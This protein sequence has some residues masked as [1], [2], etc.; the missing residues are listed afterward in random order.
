MGRNTRR[1]SHKPKRFKVAGKSQIAAS[2]R[3]APTL[4]QKP[5]TFLLN[6]PSQSMDPGMQKQVKAWLSELTVLNISMDQ[7]EL[8]VEKCA[9]PY[10]EK[11]AHPNASI[12]ILDNCGYSIFSFAEPIDSWIRALKN[13]DTL[14]KSSHRREKLLRELIHAHLEQATVPKSKAAPKQEAFKDK[15]AEIWGITDGLKTRLEETGTAT[16]S[17]NVAKQLLEQLRSKLEEI[18]NLIANDDSL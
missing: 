7:L 17:Q 6:E 15:F 12:T 8:L 5:D 3:T 9:T 2:V 1:H 13:S 4:D 14:R 11:A 10:L 16:Y 18:Q